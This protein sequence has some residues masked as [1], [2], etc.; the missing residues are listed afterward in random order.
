[1]W[2]LPNFFFGWK[3]GRGGEGL[4]AFNKMNG[5]YVPAYVAFG[6]SIT[7][8]LIV[9]YWLYPTVSNIVEGFFAAINPS[10][11]P[12]VAFVILII[13]FAVFKREHWA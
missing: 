1:M 8:V 11:H 7:W 6:G 9:N 13:A 3:L 10:N 4:Q 5:Q 2:F 12:L